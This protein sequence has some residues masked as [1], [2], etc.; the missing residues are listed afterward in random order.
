M[1]HNLQ[2]VYLHQST[3]CWIIIA[4]ITLIDWHDHGTFLAANNIILQHQPIPV[5]D[6][7]VNGHCIEALGIER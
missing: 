3:I 4:T 6:S 2:E 5:S 1:V 7:A